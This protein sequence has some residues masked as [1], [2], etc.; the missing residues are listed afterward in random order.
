MLTVKKIAD[1]AKVT[2][3][4]VRHYTRIGLLKP[5]RNPE[6]NYKEFSLADVKRVKFI[7]SAQ[8]LGF[9]LNEIDRLLRDAESG[10]SPCPTAHNI[11][12]AKIVENKTIINE[13]VQLQSQMEKAL[14][15]WDTMP[16]KTPDG[17]TIC[18]LIENW[19]TQLPIK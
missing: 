6:N 2:S 4:S 8:R 9:S 16:N 1:L 14:T 17:K 3:D 18:Y 7:R 15:K 11:I 19:D 10:K 13:L 5:N 12:Q